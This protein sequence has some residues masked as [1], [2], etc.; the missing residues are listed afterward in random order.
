[1]YLPSDA[2]TEMY[3]PVLC[4]QIGVDQEHLYFGGKAAP[5]PAIQP[6]MIAVVPASASS[7]I[8]E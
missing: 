4:T 7:P 2:A 8:T 6:S 5:S 1:M 3:T